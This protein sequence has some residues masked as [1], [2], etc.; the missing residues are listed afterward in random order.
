MGDYAE[1]LKSAKKP[2]NP[3]DCKPSDCK[4]CY[5]ASAGVVGAHYSC[6]CKASKRYNGYPLI[7]CPQDCEHY[8]QESSLFGEE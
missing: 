3:F 5:V 6:D 8:E 2:L 7:M 4:H 1:A